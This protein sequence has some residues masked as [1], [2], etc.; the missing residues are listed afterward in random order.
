MTRPH[1][2]PDSAAMAAMGR[3]LEDARRKAV[4]AGF[5]APAPRL[6]PVGAA[7]VAP[8]DRSGRVRQACALWG[9]AELAAEC[10]ARALSVREVHALLGNATGSAK[11]ISAAGIQQVRIALLALDHARTTATTDRQA[12]R[13]K[14]VAALLDR[15]ALVHTRAG[16]AIAG[17]QLSVDILSQLID[18]RSNGFGRLDPAAQAGLLRD[19]TLTAATFNRTDTK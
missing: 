14:Q 11:W 18:A 8:S 1:V 15:H 13:S 2:I 5:N 4:A 12:G 17:S 6:A 10:N 9:A 3:A 16:V 7:A 19:L